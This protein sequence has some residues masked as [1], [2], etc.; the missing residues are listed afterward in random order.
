[1]KAR[2]DFYGNNEKDAKKKPSLIGLFCEAMNDF[3]LKILI[4]SAIVSIALQVGLAEPKDRGHAWIEGFAIL[5]AVF[6]CAGVAAVNNYQKE[7]QFI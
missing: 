1:M 6:V 5:I 7:M 4:A 2:R 3:I